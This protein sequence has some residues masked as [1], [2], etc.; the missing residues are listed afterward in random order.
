MQGGDFFV[1]YTFENAVCKMGERKCW[2]KMTDLLLKLLE[3]SHF[4]SD[5]CV[6][7]GN[8]RI[9]ESSAGEKFEYYFKIQ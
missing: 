3:I 4:P 6:A 9:E 2:L 8:G 5:L 7:S 1:C